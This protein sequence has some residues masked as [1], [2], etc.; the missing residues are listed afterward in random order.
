MTLHSGNNLMYFQDMRERTLFLYLGSVLSILAMS[1]GVLIISRQ[2]ICLYQSLLILFLHLIGSLCR[3]GYGLLWAPFNFFKA[4]CLW[5]LGASLA[6]SGFFILLVREYVYEEEDQI[7]KDKY[8]LKL[9]QICFLFIPMTWILP[10]AFSAVIGEVIIL[11][12]GLYIT[13][14]IVPK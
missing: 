2:I 3:R 5:G 4:E 7:S 9:A 12:S 6:G 8:L 14:Q 1:I 10:Y 11:V 13:L